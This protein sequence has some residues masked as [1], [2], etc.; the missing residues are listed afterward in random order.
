MI[1][2]FGG[3]VIWAMWFGINERWTNQLLNPFGASTVAKTILSILLEQFVAVPI[4]YTFWDI[5]LPT[6][7]SQTQDNRSIPMQ[8]R[9]TLP[10]LL[11]DNAKVWTFANMLVYTV[12]LQYRV[13]VS[14]LVDVV[15]QSIVSSHVMKPVVDGVPT[16]VTGTTD[17]PQDDLIMETIVPRH[18]N[19]QLQQQERTPLCATILKTTK[20]RQPQLAESLP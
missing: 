15:W 5:P 13:L 6:L 3:G 11:W 18:H 2:G 17:S 20:E 1:K 19:Q 7:L 14:S 8:I 10:G 16:T 12:P 9:K 4:I